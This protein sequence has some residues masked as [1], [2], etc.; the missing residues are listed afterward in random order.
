MASYDDL[1]IW[2]D[3]EGGELDLVL[4]VDE[5]VDMDLSIDGVYYGGEPPHYEGPY[6]VRPAPFRSQVL[7]TANKLLDDDVTVEE[8]PYYKTSNPAG[9]YTAVIGD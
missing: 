5:A 3:V 4:D 6:V 7:E 9:G 8:I 1:E 2:L